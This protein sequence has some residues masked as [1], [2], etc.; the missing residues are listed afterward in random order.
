[1]SVRKSS[2]VRS[3]SKKA[4]SSKLYEQALR[5]VFVHLAKLRRG[6]KG[7]TKRLQRKY[8]HEYACNAQG[9]ENYK[10]CSTL[11]IKLCKM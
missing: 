3:D 5:Y 1:M 4:S 7:A 6:Y 10:K 2:F 8:V 11:Y 9:N